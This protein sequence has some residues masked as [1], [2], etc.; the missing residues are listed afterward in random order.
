ML[1]EE[2]DIPVEKVQPPR[3]GKLNQLKLIYQGEGMRDSPPSL[4]LQLQACGAH[5]QGRRP[6]FARGVSSLLIAR[7]NPSPV[8]LSIQSTR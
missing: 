8:P 3:P 2:G 4:D 1:A 5:S 7:I 6:G